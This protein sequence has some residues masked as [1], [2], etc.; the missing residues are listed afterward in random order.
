[1]SIISTD[2][3]MSGNPILEL[4]LRNAG[5][6][7]PFA[8]TCDVSN[9]DRMI[10]HL[11]ATQALRAFEAAAR[12]LSY[13]GAAAELC[14]THGAISHHV[15]KLEAD[16]G[17]IKLFVRDGQ[18]MLL[19]NAGQ[20][21]VLEVRRGLQALVQAMENAR[22]QT[23]RQERHRSLAISVLP[24]FAGRW[25]VPRLH[26]FQQNNM[27]LDVAVH[28]SSGLATLDGRD[29]IDMAIRYGAGRWPGLK[30]VRLMRSYLTPVCSPQYSNAFSV[31][32]AEDIS[33]ATLLRNPRQRWQP[34][35]LAAG[36]N[37][38]EPD[39]GPV[40][41]DAGLL[42]GAAIAGQGIAL[43]RLALAEEDISAGRLVRLSGIEVEDDSGWYL[44]WREPLRCHV[45]AFRAFRDW[46]VDESASSTS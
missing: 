7:K 45:A 2:W 18:R 37:E 20:V 12:H 13:S 40:Y 28:P 32:S 44:V 16:L 25:L 21:F 10:S 29:G 43:A 36:L 27:D 46:L 42:L 35:F 38:P 41:N 6:I 11:P 33:K 31:V 30:A 14:L 8:L 34:W 24:S 3:H 1:M 39:H 4:L 15:A 5:D 23:T 19:T 17:G 22:A 26:R 9:I